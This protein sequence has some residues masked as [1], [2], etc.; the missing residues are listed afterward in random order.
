M[1]TIT[2]WKGF[3]VPIFFSI[4]F[5]STLYAF[6][7]E[8]YRE[9]DLTE[10]ERYL[11]EDGKAVQGVVKYNEK[12]RVNVKALGS[13]S[14]ATEAERKL[15]ILMGGRDYAT[16]YTH[17]WKYTANDRT[18]QFFFPAGLVDYFKKEIKDGD[19][20]DLYAV[21]GIYPGLTQEVVLV[22]NEFKLLKEKKPDP[23]IISATK[24]SDF[25]RVKSLIEKDN[26]PVDTLDTNDDTALIWAADHGNLLLV[27]YLLSKGA[28]IEHKGVSGNTALSFASIMGRTEVISHLLLEGANIESKNA[29][30]RSPLLMAVIRKQPAS[31]ELLLSKGAKA[32]EPDQYGESP[33]FYSADFGYM[34]LSKALIAKGADVNRIKADGAMTPLLWA[35]QSGH[36]EV[37]KLLVENKANMDYQ[38]SID[39]RTALILSINKGFNSIALYL[40][41]Q[42][43]NPNLTLKNGQTP[44]QIAKQLND[45]ELLD[46]LIKKGAKE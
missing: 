41:D 12:I 15:L 18:Y 33:L 16:T 31:A 45:Q 20:V 44:L 23:E 10:I 25:P 24:K 22:V 40:L 1:T 14:P 21:F 5:S 28:N 17:Q 46:A 29:A 32:D 8:D 36:L 42:G 34:E 3:L 27:K 35:C 4:F 37:V 7:F 43:A 6:P 2:N 13:P 9:S 30:G 26:V 19:S 39:G 38:S 11:V